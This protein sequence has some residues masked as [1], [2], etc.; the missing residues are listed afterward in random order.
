MSPHYLAKCRTHSSDER[1]RPIVSLQTLVAL[2]RRVVMCATVI[3]AVCFAWQLACQASNVTARDQSATICTDTCF[4]SSLFTPLINRI[5]H[6]TL[7]KFSPC[8]NKPLPQLV[9]IA[10]WY[11]VYTPLHHAAHAVVNSV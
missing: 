4:Q 1:R 11:S 2:K 5:V 8:L 7:L 6:N 3:R 10:D 9:H